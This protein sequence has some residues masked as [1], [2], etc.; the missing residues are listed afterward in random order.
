VRDRSVTA[1]IWTL[2]KQAGDQ[3]NDMSESLSIGSEEKL[4]LSFEV[5]K[6]TFSR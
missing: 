5:A 4:C 6:S 3:K 1:G 2:E